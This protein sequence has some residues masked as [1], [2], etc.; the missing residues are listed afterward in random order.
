MK[1]DTGMIREYC[2]DTPP[3]LGNYDDNVDIRLRMRMDSAQDP[4]L[5][6]S[7]LDTDKKPLINKIVLEPESPSSPQ[8][9][10]SPQSDSSQDK[11]H[12]DEIIPPTHTNRIVVLR[13][14][15]T[16]DQFSS[17]VRTTFS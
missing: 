8:A 1:E 13:F 7:Q 16:G 5:I 9:N 17:D 2:H 12:L 14:D 11:Y 10:A 4:S 3:G 6:M 15:G